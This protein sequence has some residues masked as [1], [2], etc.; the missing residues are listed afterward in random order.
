M[1]GFFFLLSA[2]L[3]VAFATAVPQPKNCV[4][5]PPIN[6]RVDSVTSTTINVSFED[7]DDSSCP[8]VA[9]E[10]TWQPTLSTVT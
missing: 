7:P 8:I 4:P 10:T 1:K 3:L 6:A 9:Y 2:V 5:N